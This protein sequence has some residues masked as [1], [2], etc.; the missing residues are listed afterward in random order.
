MH[1][2]VVA[3][4][5]AAVWELWADDLAPRCLRLALD[6]VDSGVGSGF[7]GPHELTAARMAVLAGDLARA[8]GLF[9]AARRSAEQAGHSAFRAIADHDEAL[10][11]ARSGRG[12]EVHTAALLDAAVATFQSEGLDSWTQRA[13]ALK[14]QAEV[15]APPSATRPTYPDHLTAREVEVLRLVASG[16]SNR[17]IAEELVISLPTVQRHVAN[18]YAKI[19]ASGRVEATTYALRHGL[20]ESA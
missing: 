17:E 12:A 14:A 16:R 15:S 10:A 5:A 19:G 1:N 2:N 20:A 7:F 18:V 9:A 11:L 3:L 6:L 4:T 13:L 8:E